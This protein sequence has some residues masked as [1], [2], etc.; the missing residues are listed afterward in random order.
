[1]ILKTGIPFNRIYP[2]FCFQSFINMI[3]PMWLGE[4]VLIY[5]LRK[6]HAVNLRS[7]VASQIY[8]RSIDFFLFAVS[9]PLLV[10]FCHH[11]LPSKLNYSLSLL[12]AVF[13]VPL[14]LLS[15]FSRRS[16]SGRDFNLRL[17]SRLAKHVEHHLREFKV[18]FRMFANKR[19]VLRT[20]AYSIIMWV[21]SYLHNVFAIWALGF[22][23]SAGDVL[24]LFVLLFPVLLVP[25][26]GVA[27]LGTLEG[28]WFL[29]LRIIGLGAAEATLVGF[30]THVIFML[31][32]I[33]SFI[34]GL[35]GFAILALDHSINKVAA[36]S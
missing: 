33:L 24:K 35:I 29:C 26:K 17:N 11:S 34:V 31:V 18:A 19:S 1:M 8:L 21:F 7:G 28:S 16:A 15:I 12:A 32:Y 10:I 5:L 4:A 2:T 22:N 6:I 27:D 9:M 13:S 20:A 25:V 36:R 23:L 14:I 30:G 3:L